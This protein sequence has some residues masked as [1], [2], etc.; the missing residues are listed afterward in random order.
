MNIKRILVTSILSGLL[1]GAVFAGGAHDPAQ[2]GH[3]IAKEETPVHAH[4]MPMGEH[5]MPMGEHTMPMGEHVMPKGEHAMPMDHHDMPM[6]HHD[7]PMD[8]HDMP[9][10]DGAKH[11]GHQGGDGSRVGGPVDVAMA[12][13]VIQVSMLDS[14][15]FEFSPAPELKAGDI[16][17]FTV[18]NQGKIPHEFSIGDEDELNMHREMMRRMPDMVHNDGTMLTV[19]PGETKVLVWA[20]KAGGEVLLACSIPGHYEAGMFTKIRLLD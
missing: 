5:T 8:H 1:T 15:R 17:K 11:D 14:M 6:D 4:D 7:M 18:T 19:N 20:F 13:K 9:G 2:A 12:T 16:V 10:M 3:D